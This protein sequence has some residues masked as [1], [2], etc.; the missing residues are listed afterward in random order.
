MLSMQLF[1]KLKSPTFSL[2]HAIFV[3]EF[4][5]REQP[6]TCG[7]TSGRVDLEGR[8]VLPTNTSARRHSKSPPL[9]PRG[10]ERSSVTSATRENSTSSAS[11]YKP[12]EVMQK[13]AYPPYSHHQT[14]S[15]PAK[16]PWRTKTTPAKCSRAV[17][18]SNFKVRFVNW[19]AA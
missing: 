15:N 10:K 13:H 16:E 18:S 19:Q 6:R 5:G 8:R 2:F 1:L 9:A 4:R 14:M 17:P 11:R 12:T 3:A 7:Q